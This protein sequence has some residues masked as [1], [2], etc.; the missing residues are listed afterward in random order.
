MNELCSF[1][2]DHDPA[3]LAPRGRACRAKAV[4][5]LHWKDGRVSTACAAHGADA[6]TLETRKL[7]K[8]C[9]STSRAHVRC[10][11]PMGHR[12]QHVAEIGSWGQGQTR[13]P[14]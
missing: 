12:D 10:T 13:R 2:Y 11:L 3:T 8:R 9:R 7:L 4:E 1:R 6:L 5:T 14:A